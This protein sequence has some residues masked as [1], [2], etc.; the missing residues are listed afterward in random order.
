MRAADTNFPKTHSKACRVA[1]RN[2]CSL[3]TRW[4]RYRSG[5][6]VPFVLDLI[7]DLML[8]QADVTPS[9]FEFFQSDILDSSDPNDRIVGQFCQRETLK[10]LDPI[11]ELSVDDQVRIFL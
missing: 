11:R 7:K 9:Q 6:Y 10:V 4:L 5:L 8:E 2:Q 3:A 1:C